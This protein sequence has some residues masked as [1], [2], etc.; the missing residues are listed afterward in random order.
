MGGKDKSR[1]SSQSVYACTPLQLLETSKSKP[2]WNRLTDLFVT[3]STCVSLNGHLLAIGGEHCDSTGKPTTAVQKYD[4]T[5]NSWK[6]VSQMLT[7]RSKCFAAVLPD[8][9]L[10]VVGGCPGTYGATDTVTFAQ[11]VK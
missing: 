6:V 2:V 11:N 4:P 5:S 8:N 7:I 10:M 3:N 9:Q 1:K